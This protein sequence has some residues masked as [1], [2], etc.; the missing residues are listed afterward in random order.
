MNLLL[1]HTVF[2]NVTRNEW[3]DILVAGSSSPTPSL[4]ALKF[5]QH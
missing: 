5:I 2:I 4:I 1:P 3:P